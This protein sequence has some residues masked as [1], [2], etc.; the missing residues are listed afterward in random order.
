MR[1]RFQI[2][3]SPGFRLGLVF[4]CFSLNGFGAEKAALPA[5]SVWKAHCSGSKSEEV[6][7]FIAQASESKEW[8]GL[9]HFFENS[10][11]DARA[12]SQFFLSPHGSESLSDEFE[13]TVCEMLTPTKKLEP[14]QVDVN[15][16][17]PARAHYLHSIGVPV[18]ETS[19]STF[20]EFFA[21]IKPKS[22]TYVYSSAYPNNPASMFGHTFMRVNQGAGDPLLD[23]GVNYAAMVPDGE[24]G[25]L[26]VPYGLLG[27]YA[28]IFQIA[29][30]YRK[31]LEYNQAESRDLWEYDLDFTEEE[32]AQWVRHIFEL[33]FF[34]RFK[35]SF[36]IQN[37][38]YQIVRSLQ[39]IRPVYEGELG[40][41]FYVLP[42]KTVSELGVHALTDSE[43]VHYRPSLYKVSEHRFH[44]LNQ[45]QQ[46]L[47][48]EV[49]KDPTNK[50]KFTTDPM[51][52]EALTSFYDYEKIEAEEN[53]TEAMN[54]NLRNLRVQRARVGGKTNFS[55]MKGGVGRT[56][57][58]D[59]AHGT[60]MFGLYT[61]Q[62]SS[63][64]QHRTG[65][66]Y[67]LG[68]HDLLDRDTGYEALFGIRTFGANASWNF[69][70]KKMDLD[71]AT[72]LHITSLQSIDSNNHR[73]SW[74]IESGWKSIPFEH[75]SNE[76]AWMFSVKPGMTF[77]LS[78]DH[79]WAGLWLGVE[80]WVENDLPRHNQ[81]LGSPEPW[82]L[83]RLNDRLKFKAEA[84]FRIRYDGSKTYFNLN[85]DTAWSFAK[86]NEVRL[87]YQ[88]LD[89]EMNAGVMRAALQF[90]Y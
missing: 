54:Q 15:C 76:T 53:A 44:L 32:T 82:V 62:N 56:N 55:E 77:Q 16:A 70:T 83:W 7:N 79:L 5:L 49:K 57:R 75:L 14:L 73:L 28:G 90:F 37:C 60:R 46:E 67:R 9:L 48:Q 36:L 72:V 24:P 12:D 88:T 84:P 33:R 8:R 61:L 39:A 38:S 3:T 50:I 21:G 41:F 86:E 30:Y 80:A 26:Y 68:V 47:Y 10:S 29:P 25:Y 31:V 58:P 2:L 19:C 66:S 65:L 85:A 34:S 40:N 1:S 71:E 74:N 4:L 18:S 89:R 64:L 63:H 42:G 35:Y 13:A 6:Q 52:L 59:L 11:S 20:T 87:S 43:H 27:L 51:V 22:L 23:Y 17:F 69:K 78:T 81:I 45:E